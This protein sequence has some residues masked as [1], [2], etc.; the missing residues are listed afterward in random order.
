MQVLE[1]VRIGLGNH[2]KSYT[3][4]VPLHELG[5]C[6]E[7]GVWDHVVDPLEHL[8][9]FFP[10]LCFLAYEPLQLILAKGEHHGKI[11]TLHHYKRGD[12]L[13]A[14]FPRNCV[15]PFDRVD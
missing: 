7:N 6:E 1:I 5:G 3:L 12:D 9:V 14:D 13:S 15:T 2:H 4:L 11:L 8:V 10:F